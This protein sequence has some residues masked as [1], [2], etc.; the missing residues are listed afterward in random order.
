MVLERAG[1][2][3]LI[4]WVSAGTHFWCKCHHSR[5][6]SAVQE[7]LNLLEVLDPD[8]RSRFS[9]GE[10]SKTQ[11]QE[12]RQEEPLQTFLWRCRSVIQIPFSWMLWRIKQQFL[13]D[14]DFQQ[15]QYFEMMMMAMTMMMMMTFLCG[16]CIFCPFQ[17]SGY[18][19]FP[20]NPKIWEVNSV[21]TRPKHQMRIWM[22]SLDAARWLPSRMVQMKSKR[23]QAAAISSPSHLKKDKFEGSVQS[24]GHCSMIIPKSR[25]Q[26]G[27]N[28]STNG[29]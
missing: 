12:S 2:R 20:H 8:A 18:S 10:T 22:W 28:T 15:L 14:L 13:T 17:L 26:L 16:V 6:S 29:S 23:H 4:S 24:F 1:S 9:I 5:Q 21:R 3:V 27:Q 11:M 25:P 19:S 7:P